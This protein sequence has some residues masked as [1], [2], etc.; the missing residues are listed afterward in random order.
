M[1]AW[2]RASTEMVPTAYPVAGRGCNVKLLITAA[3]GWLRQDSTDICGNRLPDTLKAG[4]PSAGPGSVPEQPPVLF[5]C[6]TRTV[7]SSAVCNTNG[8]WVMNTAHQPNT[9]PMP[10]PTR[11]TYAVGW[12]RPLP[13]LWRLFRIRST[14]NSG[15]VCLPV[16]DF[17]LL[18]HLLPMR[19]ST[20]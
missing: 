12:P 16:A 17:L 9:L 6:R 1:G 15:C 8:T 19:R 18:L 2:V 11:R 14:E 13:D 4:L 10:T 7:F 3:N 5:F 20:W